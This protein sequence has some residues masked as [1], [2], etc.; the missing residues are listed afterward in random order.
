MEDKEVLI[1]INKAIMSSPDLRNKKDLILSFIDSLN[2]SSDVYEDFEK[3]MNSKKKEELDKIIEEEN[4]DEEKTY[5]F[6]G[7]IIDITTNGY[8]F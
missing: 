5:K 1:T 8:V 4:L 3:F 2:T 7:D 6:V